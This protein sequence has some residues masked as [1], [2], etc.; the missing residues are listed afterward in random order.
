VR[1]LYGNFRSRKVRISIAGMWGKPVSDR[2]NRRE[3]GQHVR[4]GVG[5]DTR[6][7]NLPR[8]C[9][10]VVTL[11]AELSAKAVWT[12]ARTS[13]ADLGKKEQIG[14]LE[15]WTREKGNDERIA[16]IPSMRVCKAAVY[17]DI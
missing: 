5:P 13:A 17:F 3:E 1:H 11:L 14:K 16:N 6:I 7:R 4:N 9:P 12:A 8:E 2:K 15:C 10:T